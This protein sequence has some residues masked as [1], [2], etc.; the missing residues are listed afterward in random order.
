LAVVSIIFLLS[1]SACNLFSTRQPEKPNSET[2]NF[3]PATNPNLVIT[4]L[5]NSISDLNVDNFIQCLSDS[6]RKDV[7]FFEF[8]PSADAMSVYASLFHNWDILSERRAFT[9]LI[10]QSSLS[11]KPLLTLNDKHFDILLPDSAVFSSNY[12]LSVLFEG[13]TSVDIYSGIMQ[14]TMTP[15]PNGL[16]SIVRWI[17]VSDGADSTKSWSYLKAILTN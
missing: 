3:V 9:N 2:G 6:S 12:S 13:E 11:Q 10:I 5:E 4:N 1:I 14:L 7:R 8:I 16:W 15:E 17:D